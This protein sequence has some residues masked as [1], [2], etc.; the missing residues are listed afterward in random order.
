MLNYEN[1]DN[2]RHP[3]IKVN[4]SNRLILRV[5]NPRLPKAQK[6]NKEPPADSIP[7]NAFPIQRQFYIVIDATGKT[8]KT[9]KEMK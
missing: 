4:T 3:A 8:H 9:Q 7:I 2:K 1:N 5:K 6:Q